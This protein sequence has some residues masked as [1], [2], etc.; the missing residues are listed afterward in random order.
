MKD[1]E[2]WDHLCMQLLIDRNEFLKIV[3]YLQ[4]VRKLISKRG[5]ASDVGLQLY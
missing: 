2:R 5:R 3:R 1:R 4:I